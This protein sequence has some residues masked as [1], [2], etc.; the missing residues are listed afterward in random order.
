MKRV[1]ATLTLTASCLLGA[2]IASADAEETL[3]AAMAEETRSDKDKARDAN[4]KPV[5][6]LKFFGLKEDMRVLELMPG[7]GWLVQNN[8]MALY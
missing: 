8:V 7:G 4:R 6:T 1:F 3:K 2:S 5:E